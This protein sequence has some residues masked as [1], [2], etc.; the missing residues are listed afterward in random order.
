MSTPSM[1]NMNFV[2]PQV[3]WSGTAEYQRLSDGGDVRHPLE[4]REA[5][6]MTCCIWILVKFPLDINMFPTLSLGDC[7]CQVAVPWK[8]IWKHM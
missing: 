1:L 4:Q 6:E 5:M 3:T 2:N 8:K 7:F